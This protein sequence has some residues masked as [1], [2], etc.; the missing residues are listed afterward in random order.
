MEHKSLWDDFIIRYQMDYPQYLE[1]CVKNFEDPKAYERFYR[2]EIDE[3]K[4]NSRV[5]LPSTLDR[6]LTFKPSPPT[7]TEDA[8]MDNLATGVSSKAKPGVQRTV[9]PWS[10]SRS[11]P[12]LGAVDITSEQIP[13]LSSRRLHIRADGDSKH[14][15]E[16]QARESSVERH[17][18]QPRIPQRGGTEKFVLRSSAPSSPPAAVQTFIDAKGSVSTPPRRLPWP[19]NATAFEDTSIRDSTLVP[20]QRQHRLKQPPRTTN[21]SDEKPTRLPRDTSSEIDTKITH[22]SQ[23]QV[24][25]Q[26]RPGTS[27]GLY[28]AKS[29]RTKTPVE[30]A[31][32]LGSKGAK[33]PR[34]DAPNIDERWKDH[35]TSLRGFTKFYQA[36]KPGRGNSWA[37]AEDLKNPKVETNPAKAL[38]MRSVDV[39]SWHL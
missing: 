9:S 10:T 24:S 37:L 14:D 31:I 23:Q 27:D 17:E 4:F 32:T 38:K 3:P 25:E 5:L 30:D 16:D 36:I 2:D 7:A 21:L 33:L 26:M 1:R 39:T 34:V 11:S 13:K 8:S 18:D 35:P 15:P 19:H 29:E 28:T 22:R 6:A 12:V 20:L